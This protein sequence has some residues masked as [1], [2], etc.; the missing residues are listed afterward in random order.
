MIKYRIIQLD[1]ICDG[2][3]KAVAMETLQML[4]SLHP[5]NE[6]VLEEYNFDPAGPRLGRDPD[7][8]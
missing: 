8:H 3:E 2:M 1:M 6:Y 7:L 4:Q 5:E